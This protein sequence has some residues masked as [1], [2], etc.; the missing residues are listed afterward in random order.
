MGTPDCNAVFSPGA[1]LLDTSV[2]C[3][4]LL[5]VRHWLICLEKKKHIDRMTNALSPM[6]SAPQAA[7]GNVSLVARGTPSPGT[8]SPLG[9]AGEAGPLGCGDAEL[10][11]CGVLGQAPASG[12][13]AGA[14]WDGLREGRR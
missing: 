1:A 5:R 8:T 14:R 4:N 11:I 6:A 9:C 3:P 13:M 7:G 10:L 12:G 2:S